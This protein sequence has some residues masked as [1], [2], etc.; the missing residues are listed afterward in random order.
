MSGS[1]RRKLTLGYLCLVVSFISQPATAFAQEPTFAKDVA[2]IFQDKCEACHRPGN[3]APMSL[4][5]YAEARPWARSIRTRVA[6]RDMPPWHIDKTVGIQKFKNDRSLTDEQIDTIVRWVDAGAQMGN[7]AD[8]PQPKKW[9]DDAWTIGKPDV[10]ITTPEKVMYAQGPDIWIDHI[11]DS[12]FTEDRYVK[13]I[14]TRPSKTGR[15]V[16]H[17]ASTYL[18]QDDDTVLTA[19]GEPRPITAVDETS[20]G[21]LGEFAP[22]KYGDIFADNTGILI[23]AGAR[24]RFNMH[25]FAVGEEV[26]AST[27]I[28]LVLYP[29]GVVPKYRVIDP[30]MGGGCC[31][32]LDIPANTI[33][34]HDHY[35]PVK[36]P[37]RL[38]SYQPHMH[39]R[40]KAQ[41]VSAIYPD[42]RT[43]ILSNVDRF[44]FN[45]HVSYVYDDDVAPL[46]PA[47][48]LLHY[49]G[50]HD[51][52]A[53]N[54]RNPD[55]TQ[56]VGYGD[57]SIDD[58]FQ[59]HSNLVYLDEE[60]YKRQV[61][62]REAK[63]R[64]A[65]GMQ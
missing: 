29:K 58:M 15:R 50:I 48:T 40:G 21:R 17:H 2:P 35:F 6:R 24:I 55:P 22:G 12:G 61:A 32:D 47:G 56:W 10:I 54:P 44:D 62:E 27:S 11:V 59:V 30:N 60:D 23:K 46:L 33:T 7:P 26:T 34:R 18:I 1:A 3:M 8:L 25:Y 14:E 36:R 63:K 49:V 20:G 16:V 64:K 13:A 57:R 43:E 65:G 31:R 4:V 41:S 42:G 37:A 45:W 38:L 19:F 5:T 39:M 9:D 52:T 28:G 51:N 53:A